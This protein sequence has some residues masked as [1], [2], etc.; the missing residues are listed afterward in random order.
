MKISVII[1]C[2]NEQKTIGGCIESVLNQTKKAEEI[3]IVNDGSTDKSAKIISKFRKIRL[4]NLKK[5]T[6]N[7]SK[8]LEIALKQVIG[9]IIVFTD[10]D[11]FLDKNFIK[12]AV[13]YF[14]NSKISAISG[15]VISRENNW[16]TAARELEY[17]I[18][19]SLHKKAQDIVKSIF[20]ISGA[21]A[22]FRASVFKNIKFDHDTITEDLDIT[23]KLHK[24]K[25]QIIYRPEIIA[26]TNDPFDLKSYIR[27]IK[28]WYTGAYQ[29][30]KKHKSIFG[31]GFIGKIE[32]PLTIVEGLCGGLFFLAC[33]VLFFIFPRIIGLI[34]L[35]DFIILLLAC[36]YGIISMKRVDLIKG[37][38]PFFIL[39]ALGNIIWLWAFFREI[40]FNKKVMK[41]YRADR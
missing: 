10:A 3:I 12:R 2:F 33:P 41:W 21:C 30:F 24:L 19:F 7:K 8:A 26:Y 13:K 38:L 9:D 39:K 17:I 4:I 22:I 15:K 16:L 23:L 40:V 20:V 11:S 37:I 5:N 6:G 29:N 28:R 36:I 35:V 25:E 27:Q 34:F 31:K 18:T 32:I 14:K 1:P